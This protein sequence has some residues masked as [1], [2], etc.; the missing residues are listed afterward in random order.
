MDRSEDPVGGILLV[1]QYHEGRSG[2]ACIS[3]Y[4]AQ[5]INSIDF[6]PSNETLRYT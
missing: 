4:K 1:D 3:N 2:G 6:E 5:Y